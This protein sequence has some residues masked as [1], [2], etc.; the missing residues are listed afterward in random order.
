MTAKVGSNPRV[1]CGRGGHGGNVSVNPSC[2]STPAELAQGCGAQT[3]TILVYCYIL[4][5][6]SGQK[7]GVSTAL[8]LEEAKS[9][10]KSEG[11]CR[12]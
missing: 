1:W 10:H 6:T 4:H 2:P 12:N 9:W 3:E 7:K 8:G 5:Q 11:K